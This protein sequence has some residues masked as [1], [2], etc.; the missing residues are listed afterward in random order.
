MAYRPYRGRRRRRG[1]GLG[2]AL[3]ALAA[4]ALAVGMSWY[5]HLPV[6][7]WVGSRNAEA[8]AGADDPVFEP[9][10]SAAFLLERGEA[11]F[12]AGRW[13]DAAEAFGAAAAL[14]PAVGD[15][16]A[17]WARALLN[18]N[19]LDAAVE[20]GRQ[21]VEVA[22]RSAY[23]RAVL[24]VALD[25]SGQVDEA[26]AL[27]RQA[28]QLDARSVAAHAALV[29]VLTDQYRLREADETLAVALELGPLDPEVHRVRGNLHEMRA[30]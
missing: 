11:A 6:T 7:G 24:A 16:Q 28:V 9:P 27:A 15:A 25:W 12:V 23:A 5:L 18:Q 30:D 10:K 13:T 22:P 20:R 4:G 2:I 14:E 29:E 3:G 17:R 21:A 19:R 26:S 8:L 1:S